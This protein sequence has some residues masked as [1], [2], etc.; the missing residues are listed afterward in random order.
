MQLGPNAC[1]ALA[2]LGVLDR[3]R[4]VATE[5]EHLL[6]H[7][8]KDGAVLVDL[9]LRTLAAQRWHSSSLV[10]HRGD[11]HDVLLDAAK[12]HPLIKVQNNA[13]VTDVTDDV[14]GV[15]LQLVMHNAPE[16]RRHD[17]LVVAEGVGSRLRARFDGG[18]GLRDTGRVAW[19]ALVAAHDAPAFARSATTHLWLGP[20]AHLVHYPLR[21]GSVINV[22]AISGRMAE[23]LVVDDYD[24]ESDDD[25]SGQHLA[26]AFATFSEDARRLL[27]AVT[28]WRM[29]PLLDAAPLTSLAKGRIA[30]VGDAAHPMVPFMAQGAGQAIE[31]AVALGAGFDRHPQN[32]VQALAAYSAARW[33]RAGRVQS[34]SGRQAMIYHMSGLQA[35]V[36]DLAMQ[37]LGPVGM[38]LQLDWL[39][40]GGV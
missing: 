30:L 34:A 12:A 21:G 27:G 17:A 20:N 18:L 35:R 24:A 28:N 26:Q 23:E 11:L 14:G 13:R 3:V 4:T 32:P 1:R 38:A 6:I 5:P 8:G 39:Y 16:V 2:N 37:A 7:R 29:W 9:P 25:A 31:D 40:H 15:D 33:A 19:R 36:R 10:I 22:V